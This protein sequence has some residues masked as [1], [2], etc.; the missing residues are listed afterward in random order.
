M[1]EEVVDSAHIRYRTE[2][3]VAVVTLDRARYRNA[4][5]RRM[6]EQLDEAFDRAVADDDVRVIVLEGAGDHFSSGHD[7]GT[8]DELADQA[9]RPYGTDVNGRYSRSWD[10]NVANSLRWREVPK[11]T[12]A[13]VQGWCIYGGWIV[14]SAMDLIVAADDARFV[15]GLVQYFTMAWDVGA[16]KTKEIL[17]QSRIV[18]AEEA[19]RLGFVNMVVPRAE[20][21]SETMKLAQRIAETDPFVVRMVKHAVNNTLDIAGYRAS[22]TANHSHYLLAELGGSIRPDLGGTRLPGVDKAVRGA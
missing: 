13:A 14:A 3:P 8:P 20:L 19:C 16:R 22:V 18:E 10:L 17:F 1:G 21:E 15:P 4:Q 9:E 2:G 11:P 5:S 12:I 7:L 6:R